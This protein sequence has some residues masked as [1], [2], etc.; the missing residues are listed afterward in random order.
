MNQPLL[1]SIP[2]TGHQLG[3]GR[4]KV[5]GLIDEGELETIHIG[6]RHLVIQASIKR[7]VERLAQQAA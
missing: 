4:T 7:L 3:V 6:D 1:V 2:E 5:Y